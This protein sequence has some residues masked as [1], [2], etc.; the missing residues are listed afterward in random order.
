MIRGFATPPVIIGDFG[1]KK[2]RLNNNR[3]M[4]GG[5]LRYSINSG[6]LRLIRAQE[7]LQGGVFSPGVVM[8]RGRVVG[9]RA[10]VKETG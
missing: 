2:R 8:G 9:G 5:K 1:R 3:Q 6:A 7:I 4:G 10:C